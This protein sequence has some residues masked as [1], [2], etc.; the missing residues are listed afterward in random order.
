MDE[1]ALMASLVPEMAGETE[2]DDQE[3]APLVEE[4]TGQE[5]EDLTEEPEQEEEPQES[6]LEKNYKELRKFATQKAM[7]AAD[8]RRQLASRQQEQV[9]PPPVQQTKAQATLSD[10]IDRQVQERV[11]QILEPI[12]QQ[13]E[14][15][16]IQAT[17]RALSERYSDFDEVAQG[18]VEM[19][20]S[21]PELF[22]INDGIELAYLAARADYLEKSAEA[23]AK[24]KMMASAAAKTQKRVVSETGTVTKQ[25]Q[26]QQTPED[27]IKASIVGVRGRSSIF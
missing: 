7:E 22:S 26:S 5:Q 15:L 24:A 25:G 6:Q 11:N 13:Q 1:S 9:A 8:L 19:L 23:K 2:M 14:D 17:V 3:A 12:Q 10:I 27:L 20:E 21:R 16:R 18:F 4:E